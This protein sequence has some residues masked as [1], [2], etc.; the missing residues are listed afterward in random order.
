MI[1]LIAVPLGWIAVA[2]VVGLFVGRGI[3]IESGIESDHPAM[4]QPETCPPEAAAAGGA[5]ERTPAE[6]PESSLAAAR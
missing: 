1:W 6:T 5:D 2:L 3:G 4:D